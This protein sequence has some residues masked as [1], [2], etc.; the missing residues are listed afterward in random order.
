MVVSILSTAVTCAQKAWK[1]V[2]QELSFILVDGILYFL[3]S[4]HGDRKHV[5]VQKHLRQGILEENHSGPMAGHFSGERLY[6]S[7]LCHWWWPGMYTDTVKHCASCPQCA[8]VSG[9]GHVNRP[10]LHPILNKLF[11]CTVS[12]KHL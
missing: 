1:I 11:L 12:Q 10:P 5:A 8:I 6:K 3:D 2:V 7:L 4:R 9:S